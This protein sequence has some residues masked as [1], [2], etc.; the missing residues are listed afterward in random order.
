DVKP[1][2][3]FI[4]FDAYKQVLATPV[5]LVLLATPPH[6]RPLHLKAAI[7]ARKHVFAEK[8]IAVDA[9]GVRAVL[10]ASAAAKHYNLALVS[11]LCYRYEHAKQETMKRVHDGAVGNIIALHT[12]YNMHGLWMKRRKAEWSDME[13]Q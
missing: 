3:C 5:D 11:G 9:P 6:F 12:N 13:W 7:E 10:A 1:D 2:Y 4:G 8:P